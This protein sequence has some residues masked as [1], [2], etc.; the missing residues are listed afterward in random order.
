MLVQMQRV[1]LNTFDRVVFNE[2][3][4]TKIVS[5]KKSAITLDRYMC[6]RNWVVCVKYVT[7]LNGAIY[8]L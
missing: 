5:E 4:S 8:S 3:F 7:P 6:G 1:N 2:K